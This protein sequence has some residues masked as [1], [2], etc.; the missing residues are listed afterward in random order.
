MRKCR[1]GIILTLVYLFT[2]V[3]FLVFR[4]VYYDSFEYVDRIRDASWNTLVPIIR[5]SHPPVHT[6]YIGLAGAVRIITHLPAAQVYTLLSVFFGFFAV[7]LWYNVLFRFLRN[8]RD[9]FWGTLMF[10]LFPGFWRTSTNILY[11][12]LLLAFQAGAMAATLTFFKTNRTRYMVAATLCFTAAQLTFIGNIFSVLPIMVLATLYKPKQTKWVIFWLT[13][14]IATALVIDRMILGSWSALIQNYVTHAGDTISPTGGIL[15]IFGRILR[16]IIFLT[17]KLTHPLA[18]SIAIIALLYLRR[19][20]RMV[21]VTLAFLAISFAQMQ[22]WHAGYYGRIGILVLFPLS[23]VLGKF[24]GKRPL[25]GIGLCIVLAINILIL[26]TNQRKIPYITALARWTQAPHT[27]F[28][29]G[30][31]TRFAFAPGT[32]VFIVRDPQND[33]PK[34]T[35]AVET[36]ERIFLDK[37]VLT[38]PYNQPD[39]WEY[40]LVSKQNKE[41]ILTDW[42]AK[43]CTLRVAYDYPSL[44]PLV[45]YEATA[46]NNEQF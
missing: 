39:G 26:G 1:N 37:S 29:T 43:R 38:Y 14:S 31:N 34:L 20:K 44:P 46:C 12:P 35:K 42:F 27:L 45:I 10:T 2:R 3:P 11:E 16:N 6:L 25:F 13:T 40:Q 28:V 36:N 7:F 8:S 22:Y 24:L 4:P 32:N 33:I 23:L 5:G 15:V 17:S 18:A 21:W 9:A 30:D 41:G 19:E